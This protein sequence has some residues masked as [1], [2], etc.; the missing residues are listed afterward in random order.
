MNSISND[1]IVVQRRGA[2][3]V[4]SWMSAQL[5]TTPAADEVR[6]R[7]EATG[8]S[9]YD[10]MIRRHWFFGF[11]KTPYTPGEDVV[12]IVEAIGQGVTKFKVGQRVAGWTFGLGGGYSEMVVHSRQRRG[13]NQ[14]P[15][16]EFCPS[17][18]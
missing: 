3:D 6:I 10:L 1:R 11:T 5:P 2:P 13:P 8:V 7:V 12:G 17:H 18:P 4:L 9:G 15:N 14:L 16:R